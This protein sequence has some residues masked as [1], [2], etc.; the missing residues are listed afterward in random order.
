MATFVSLPAIERQIQEFIFDRSG[1]KVRLNLGK[2]GQVAIETVSPHGSTVLGIL[3]VK[4]LQH[5]NNY[6]VYRFPYRK[7]YKASGKHLLTLRVDTV[8][9]TVCLATGQVTVSG[10]LAVDWFVLHFPEV[11]RVYQEGPGLARQTLNEPFD[12]QLRLNL[13]AIKKEIFNKNLEDWPDT[14]VDNDL[15][16]LTAPEM[17]KHGKEQAHQ[18]DE[19]HVPT[20]PLL[21]EKAVEMYHLD[22][23][24]SPSA[25]EKH[26]HRLKEGV[27]TDGATL[28]TVWTSL[29]DR[30]FADPKTKVFIITSAI[31]V[32]SLERLCQL[33]L[34]HRLTASLEMLA[35]P[36]RSR[37]GQLAQIRRD[38]MLKLPTKDQVFAEYKVYNAMVYPGT[39]FQA[40]FIAGVCG[41]SVEVLLTSADAEQKH[42]Q[43]RHS[44][45]AV[46]QVISA[47][48]FDC[49]LLAP[50]VSSVN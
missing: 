47:N 3:W 4:V 17:W 7:L 48:E 18:R 33:V 44:C 25:L 9:V 32:P 2:E 36:L 6:P 38:V 41:E 40:K 26:L 10:C 23:L 19:N 5:P 39:E 8:T 12:A 1:E 50:I 27:L 30:W 37:C 21:G 24:L 16:V 29:L 42:F 28:Y 15:E 22:N 14:V 35:T 43:E 20:F 13:R 45:T 31:D 46:F 34:N 49:R 11:L